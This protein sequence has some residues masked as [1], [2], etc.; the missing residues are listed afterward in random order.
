MGGDMDTTEILFQVSLV[1]VVMALVFL[2]VVL[3]RLYKVLTDIND[4][5]EITKRRARDFDLWLN[6]IESS[7]DNI[8]DVMK[9]MAVSFQ[10]L[11]KIK[12]KI[13]AFFERD[14]KEEKN[15]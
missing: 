13:E 12:N 1:F 5:T 10:K 11:T 6:Q 7:V 4:T 14:T 2:I 3:W 8:A 15:E 9:G